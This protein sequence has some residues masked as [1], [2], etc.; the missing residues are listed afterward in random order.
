MG[1][2]PEELLLNTKPQCLAEEVPHQRLLKTG[3][4]L[5]RNIIAHQ[6]SSYTLDNLSDMVQGCMDLRSDPLMPSPI[7]AHTAPLL[8]I[9]E[10]CLL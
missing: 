4:L 1:K 10:R 8:S 3:K 6:P 9:P 7:L 5:W 2:N